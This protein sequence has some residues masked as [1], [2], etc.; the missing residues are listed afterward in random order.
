MP[1]NPRMYQKTISYVCKRG[2]KRKK[3]TNTP[4]NKDPYDEQKSYE[5][6]STTQTWI[7]KAYKS[8]I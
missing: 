7:V 1:C 5:T 3:C 6:S 2:V 8:I 4:Q